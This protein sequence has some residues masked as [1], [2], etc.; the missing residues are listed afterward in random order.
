MNLGYLQK[1]ISIKLRKK[2]IFSWH[3]EGRRRKAQDLELDPC[4]DPLDKGTDL[5]IRILIRTK[6]SG[7]LNTET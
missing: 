3:L 1:G 6:I 5:R 2:I 4:P 7:I